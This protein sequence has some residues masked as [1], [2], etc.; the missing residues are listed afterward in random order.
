[1]YLFLKSYLI[2]AAKRKIEKPDKRATSGICDFGGL[3]C[4]SIHAHQGHFPADSKQLE[5]D[6]NV[7]K[8]RMSNLVNLK[9]P[10]S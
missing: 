10:D 4:T 7:W 5:R 1:M 3:L 8:D 9:H 6:F 2:Y